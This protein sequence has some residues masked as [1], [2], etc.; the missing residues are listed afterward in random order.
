MS[1][2]HRLEYLLLV[3]LRWVV[4]SLPLESAQALGAR[5][6]RIGYA[7]FAR[8][9]RVALDNLAR[10]FPGMPA[11]ELDQIARGAFRN[12]GITFI[13]LLWAPNV[14]GK[15]LDRLITAPERGLIGSLHARGKGLVILTAHFGNWELIA[16]ALPHIGGLGISVIVQPQSN[17][18]ADR[19]ISSHRAL[20]GNRL[21]PRGISIREILGT[22][23]RGGIVALAADQSGPKEGVFVRFFG[24][25]AATPQGP[26][27]FALRGRVPIL[28]AFLIRKKD[29][30]Y[31]MLLERVPMDDLD[32]NTEANVAELT[33]RH[34]AILERAIRAHP[35]QWLW[36]HKRWKNTREEAPL[37]DAEAGSPDNRRAI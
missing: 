19:L 15:L 10:A 17:E 37:I 24:R 26:A 6:G 3:A 12:Y 36:M 8:R 23:D 34:T 32:G 30:T 7:L 28:M 25:M 27:A 16:L 5:L 18:L 20:F 21:I 35:E 31:Q 4:V 22:L 29:G 9:R 13:E 1:I 2:Q 33:Q 11:G 14:T